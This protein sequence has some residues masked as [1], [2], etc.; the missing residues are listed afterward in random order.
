MIM[1]VMQVAEKLKVDEM[2]DLAEKVIEKH[3]QAFNVLGVEKM[4]GRKMVEVQLANGLKY[5]VV[6]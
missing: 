6:V 1:S 4:G 2:Q 5:K 3:D